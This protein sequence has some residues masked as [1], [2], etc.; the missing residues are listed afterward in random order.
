[1][2][3][4]LNCQSVEITENYINYIIYYFLGKTFLGSKGW[5]IIILLLYMFISCINQLKIAAGSQEFSMSF[6]K[7]I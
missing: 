6:S 7:T 2:Y 5:L 3:M 4:S 1:M